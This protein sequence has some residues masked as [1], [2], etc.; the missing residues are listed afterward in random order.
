VTAAGSRL[1][2]QR[3]AAPLT[4]PAADLRSGSMRSMLSSRTTAR[5]RRHARHFAARLP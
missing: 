3:L 2:A 1:L 4:D 5:A